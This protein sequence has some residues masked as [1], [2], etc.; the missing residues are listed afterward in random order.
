MAG[1]GWGIASV[2]SATA[3]TL[4]CSHK[5]VIYSERRQLFK[6]PA[7]RGVNLELN[8]DSGAFCLSGQRTAVATP[9]A[10]F[11]QSHSISGQ[12]TR[13]VVAAAVRGVA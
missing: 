8:V 4:K 2:T 6:P 5:T 11:F 10:H 9:V 13:G 12:S 3:R 1:L 7:S